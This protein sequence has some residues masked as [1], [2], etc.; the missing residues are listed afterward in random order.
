MP[1]KIAVLHCY[2]PASTHNLCLLTAHLGQPIAEAGHVMDSVV[3]HAGHVL[4]ALTL[5]DDSDRDGRGLC[6]AWGRE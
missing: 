6:V 3:W 4:D 2:D 1:P 5:D